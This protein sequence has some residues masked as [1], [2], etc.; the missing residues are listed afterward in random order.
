MSDTRRRVLPGLLEL[1]LGRL[2]LGLEL[3]DA[4]RLLDDRA[5]VGGT[6]RHDLA[7][8]A[9]LDD[10]VRLGADAGAEEEVGHVAQPAR[11]LVDE[12]V[13]RAVAEQ[14]PRDGDLGVAA[15][16]DLGLV[17]AEEVAHGLGLRRHRRTRSRRSRAR[18]RPTAGP[19]P[20][21]RPAWPA[22]RRWAPRPRRRAPSTSPSPAPMASSDA[23]A[24]S[25]SAS[26]DFMAMARVSCENPTSSK[27]SDT[28]AI[29]AGP[30][31]SDPAK[32]TSSMALPRRC[33]ADCSPMH[34]RMASTMLDLPQPFGPTTAVTDESMLMVARSQNDLNP[35]DLY[36]LD[37]HGGSA[38][39]MPGAY[40][41][42]DR[43]LGAPPRDPECS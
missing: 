22:R 25:A 34:H 19:A 6:R 40:D 20:R 41:T 39:T 4:G 9:L 16:V 18:P 8:A 10:R 42:G 32:I 2:F 28:S 43:H 12:V 13:R 24:R 37:S 26:S 23:A 5:A 3:G 33:L 27:V 1:L 15:E 14:A 29:G 11:L 36:A 31:P 30:R 17:I 7:D 21:P 38:R 35:D